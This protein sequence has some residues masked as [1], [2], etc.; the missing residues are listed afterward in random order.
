MDIRNLA[1]RYGDRLAM[2]GNIDVMILDSND[3]E[4]IEEE[5][6]SKFAAGMAT[7]GYAYH[8]DHSVPPTV[9]WDTYRF[10]IQCVEK[11]GQYA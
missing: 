2:F 8:S 1:P 5:I 10:I 3:R 6:R 4:R 9:S 7:R 11:Y